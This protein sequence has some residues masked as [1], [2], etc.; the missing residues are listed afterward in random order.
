MLAGYIAVL[1][2]EYAARDSVNR[3]ARAQAANTLNMGFQVSMV[4]VCLGRYYSYYNRT[5]YCI[6]YTI[7]IDGG[8]HCSVNECS[9]LQ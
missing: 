6:L 2:Y 3:A 4:V 5:I 7:Y 8:V 9:N 1:V